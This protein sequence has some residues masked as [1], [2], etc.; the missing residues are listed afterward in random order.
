MKRVQQGFTLIELMIVVA[1]I[2]ILAAV[3][4]PQYRDYTGKARV[5]SALAQVDGVK[6]AVALCIQTIGTKTGCTT[7]SND[8]L[9]FAATKEIASAKAADG[10]IDVVLNKGIHGDI[11]GQTIKMTPTEDGARI[12]WKNECAGC[13]KGAVTDSITKNNP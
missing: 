6:K 8:V 7:G 5:G 10:I 12:S 4:I 2:G 9:D 13:T 3:A 1:I 11:D